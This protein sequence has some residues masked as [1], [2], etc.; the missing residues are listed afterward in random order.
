MDNHVTALVSWTWTAGGVAVLTI[1]NAPMNLVSQAVLAALNAALTELAAEPALRCLVVT[2]AGARAFCAGA[3]IKEFPAFIA[4]DPPASAVLPGQQA[5]DRLAALPCPT[6]AAIEGVA[7]GGGCELALACDLRVAGEQARLGLPET[8]LGIFPCYGGTQRLPRLVGAAV[9]KDLIF[10]GRQVAADEAHRLG[11][12]NRVVPAGQALA[13]A[14]TLAEMLAA[15]AGRALAAAKQAIDAGQALPLTDGL[16]LEA[17]LAG[18]VFQSDDLR[19][20]V[21]AFAEKR[22]PVF[23]HR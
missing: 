6:I 23:Q 10:T 9:A 15:R 16:A 14:V 20:G 1:D 18:E 4:A 11:L 3:D 5:F 22:P 7:L 13:A 21:A 17:M 2:G 19:E 12:V 8:G